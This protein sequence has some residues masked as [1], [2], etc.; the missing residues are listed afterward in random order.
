MSITNFNEPCPF[1][2]NHNLT[3]TVKNGKGEIYCETCKFYF[4]LYTNKNEE[5]T[6]KLIVGRWNNR[7]PPKQI[8]NNIPVTYSIHY[9]YGSI[10]TNI[11]LC[12]LETIRKEM[13]HLAKLHTKTKKFSYFEI[14]PNI[15]ETIR[16]YPKEKLATGIATIED[17]AIRKEICHILNDALDIIEHPEN[18]SNKENL[19]ES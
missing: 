17:V 9:K 10:D 4:T 12:T 13:I 8:K 14:K 16:F 6:R 2:G 15:Y 1:C 5:N 18:Y 3:L 19:H 11:G 7:I